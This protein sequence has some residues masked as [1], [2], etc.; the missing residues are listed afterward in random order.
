M[1][2][3]EL[4]EFPYLGRMLSSFR[5]SHRRAA[6]T[7]GGLW[8]RRTFPGLPDK[9]NDYPPSE[10]R[11]LA[12]SARSFYPVPRISGTRICPSL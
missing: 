7:L 2:S 8:P 11:H 1:R 5:G 6:L 4:T 10:H 9:Y 3:H 12:W